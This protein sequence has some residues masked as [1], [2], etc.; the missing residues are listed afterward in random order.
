MG[1]RR[2]EVRRRMHRSERRHHV[3]RD[4]TTSEN[5]QSQS[6]TRNFYLKLVHNLDWSSYWKKFLV[7]KFILTV[8]KKTF[9][10][11]LGKFSPTEAT[12]CS[13]WISMIHPCSSQSSLASAEFEL[14]LNGFHIYINFVFTR[15]TSTN[16]YIVIN[17]CEEFF[18]WRT[19]RCSQIFTQLTCDSHCQSWRMSLSKVT[20][21]A[22]HLHNHQDPSMKDCT[23]LSQIGE[24][25]GGTFG[26]NTAP[27]H[28]AHEYLTRVKVLV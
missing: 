17:L 16:M 19:V 7:E 24:E 3:G 2:K 27:E 9:K 18:L 5:N 21:P 12:Q 15:Y 25:G 11:W 14:K 20:L 22:C 26:R 28:L 6:K 8:C 4:G 1:W 10:L 13:T 23:L